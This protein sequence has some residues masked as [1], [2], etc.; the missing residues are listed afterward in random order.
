MLNRK[1][2]ILVTAILLMSQSGSIYAESLNL[3]LE[4]AKKI[5]LENNPSIKIAREGVKKSRS[6][7]TEARANLMPVISGFSSFQHA[8]ELP[9]MVLNLPPEMG[10][11]RKFKMGTENNIVYGI[12][13]SQP[14]FTGGAIWNG[15]QMSRIGRNI[16]EAQLKSIEQK[17]LSDVTGAYYHVLFANSALDVALEALESSEKN[18]EQVNKFYDAGKSSRFDVLRAEVQV[19]N[20]KPMVVSSKNGLRLAESNLSLILGISDSVNYVFKEKLEFTESDLSHK[21]LDE[22][23]GIALRNRPEVLIMQEQKLITRK[24]LSIAKAALMPSVI[25]GTSYQYQGMRD[26]MDFTNDD[27]YK[28]FNS[29]LTLSI[30]LF[31]GLKNS[32][33][34]Q[35][36]KIAIKETGYQEE[37]LI[38]VIKLEVK[39]AY[40]IMK[41]AEEKVETQK[42]T[43]ELATEALRLANLMYTEGASTQLDVL[44]ANLAL[45]QAKM[46]Y[47]QSLFEYNVALANLKKAINQL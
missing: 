24:Q 11:Q 5:A 29:T 33:K 34:M 2:I 41:E 28:S 4:T 22:L 14:L 23:L 15:F 47:Q 40:F 45:N 35:Q 36:A 25:F 7:V 12:N 16:A 20:F 32:S 17:L 30:P 44:N 19:A 26:D 37:S 6:M 13:V 27:F 42:K 46:N 31:S 39:S 38:N 10:G 8:W 1:I 3:D 21:N 43:I 9:T 18:L